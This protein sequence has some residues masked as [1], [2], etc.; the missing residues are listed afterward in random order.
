MKDQLNAM[1]DSHKGQKCLLL[2]NGPSLN[3]VPNLGE[4]AANFD[5]VNARCDDPYAS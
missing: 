4:F 5:V 1:K 3:K 2:A